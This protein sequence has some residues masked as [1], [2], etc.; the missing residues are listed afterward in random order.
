MATDRDPGKYI[1]RNVRDMD[2]YTPGEQPSDPDVIKLNTNENPYPPS[3]AINAVLE[4]LALAKMRRYPDPLATELRTAIAQLHGCG[5]DHVFAGNG[6]D[7]VLA[8]CLRAFVEAYGSVGYFE[9][10]YSLY[11][12]LAAIHDVETRPVLLTDDFGWNMPS[13]YQASLFF[14]TQPNA[15]TGLIYPREQVES[16]CDDFDGII[17]IDEAYVD[18]A[19]RDCMDLALSRSNVLVARSFSKSYSLAGI[20]LGYLVG[21]PSLIAALYKIKDSYNINQLT[22]RIGLAA[23]RDSAY[24]ESNCERIIATRKRV[25]DSLQ[26]MD[27]EVYP[28]QTNFLW[29]RPCRTPALTLFEELKKERIFVRHFPGEVTGEFLRITVGTDAEMDSF[30][31]AVRRCQT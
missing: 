17:V 14:L 22:Q 1:R 18:F 21:N 16:F 29:V 8:L 7:E 6:S 2:G 12:V 13:D 24:M 27:F 11:P 19:A 28:T 30:L 23:V 5:I 31:A 15:P 25:A 4:N 10:S 26:D 3:P 9:P 20:R